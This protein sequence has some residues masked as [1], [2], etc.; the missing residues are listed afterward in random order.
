MDG[1]RHG[2]AI[3]FS[4]LLDPVLQSFSTFG[5]AVEV[6]AWKRNVNDAEVSQQRKCDGPCRTNDQSVSMSHQGFEE[7]LEGNKTRRGSNW[8]VE[9]P[10]N[11]FSHYS[12]SYQKSSD[13]YDDDFDVNMNVG[14]SIRRWIPNT[15]PSRRRS[16]SLSLHSPQ[17]VSSHHSFDPLRLQKVWTQDEIFEDTPM[18][19]QLTDFAEKNFCLEMV[20]FCD[21]VLKYEKEWWPTLEKETATRLPDP[22][23]MNDSRASD[24]PNSQDDVY[25]PFLANPTPE[26]TGRESPCPLA[27]NFLRAQSGGGSLKLQPLPL[28][29]TG[30]ENFGSSCSLEQG[31][32]SSPLP[33][34]T[35]PNTKLLEP[36][37]ARSA[38][39]AKLMMEKEAIAEEKRP[40]SAD[41]MRQFSAVSAI[42]RDYICPGAPNEVNVSGDSRTELGVC[43]KEPERF[44]EKTSQQRCE[45]FQDLKEEVSDA[46]FYEKSKFPERTA[47]RNGWTGGANLGVTD[48]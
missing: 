38:K 36:L 20:E 28:P 3:S 31:R 40:P 42:Y 10:D 37:N 11:S 8:S 9:D 33:E 47:R 48:E 45:I 34:G 26:A 35:E 6:E 22:L 46:E 43:V 29:T 27:P 4:V 41:Q 1:V 23:D 14:T 13:D 21:A 15:R 7:C 12:A 44:F 18:L 19:S 17:S 5:A 24:A 2:S 32:E 39:E 16:V 25:S 30:T